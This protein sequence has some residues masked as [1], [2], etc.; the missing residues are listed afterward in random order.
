MSI[1]ALLLLLKI[2]TYLNKKAFIIFTLFKVGDYKNN[3]FLRYN[4]LCII[5]LSDTILSFG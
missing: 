3:Y 1:I 2:Q 5:F 4:Y